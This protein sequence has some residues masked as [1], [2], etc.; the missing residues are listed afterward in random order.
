MTYIPWWR[1]TK[2]R[3]NRNSS[4][5]WLNAADWSVF[6]T[7]PRLSSDVRY[8][9]LQQIGISLN[10][11]CYQYIQLWNNPDCRYQSRWIVEACRYDRFRW[12][13]S[14]RLLF[15]SRRLSRPASSH[16]LNWW[17]LPQISTIFVSLENINAFVK[18]DSANI[19]M[20]LQSN[21]SWKNNI[22][23]TRQ[24]WKLSNNFG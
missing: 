15:A 21:L 13:T 17:C 24:N 19:S 20:N 6:V 4:L 8:A 16:S 12:P 3:D 1:L 11:T 22:N 23:I 14:R 18:W 7:I 5:A 10:Q 2:V 9:L